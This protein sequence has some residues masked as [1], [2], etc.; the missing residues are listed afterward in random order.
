MIVG[1]YML[2]SDTFLD[3]WLGIIAL[4]T[5]IISF[6]VAL[7][8]WHLES[9]TKFK[10]SIKLHEDLNCI[11]NRYS[12][13]CHGFVSITNLSKTT[14]SIET[15][16]FKLLNSNSKYPDLEYIPIT[17]YP[18]IIE[19]EENYDVP[20][21]SP[22]IEIPANLSNF[23]SVCAVATDVH[24]T[25]WRSKERI[26]IGMLRKLKKINSQINSSITDS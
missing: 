12:Y 19:S 3:K 11:E 6:Y 4:L 1:K 26:T 2:N 23:Q 17:K 22:N 15:V 20:I 13:R 14:K 8:N 18:I 10:V 5:S 9:K 16:I 24:G 7:R 21:I 25:K